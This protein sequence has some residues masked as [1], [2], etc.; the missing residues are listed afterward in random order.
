MRAEPDLVEVRKASCMLVELLRPDVRE[1][2]REVETPQSLEERRREQRGKE[3][4]AMVLRAPHLA[5]R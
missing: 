2:V 3:V 5:N 4:V 1:V